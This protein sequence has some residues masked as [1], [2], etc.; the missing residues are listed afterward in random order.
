MLLNRAWRLKLIIAYL[1]SVTKIFSGSAIMGKARV[2]LVINP[3]E[4]ANHYCNFFKKLWF[5]F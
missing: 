4:Q 3:R 2:V 1:T 5:N